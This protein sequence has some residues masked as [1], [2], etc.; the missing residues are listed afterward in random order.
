MAATENL[1][2]HAPAP[3]S[4]GQ[5]IFFNILL[6]DFSYFFHFKILCLCARVCDLGPESLK[7]KIK[8]QLVLQKDAVSDHIS[9]FL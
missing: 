4:I 7:T 6:V 3:V 2:M 1:K 8:E 5:Y 9:G